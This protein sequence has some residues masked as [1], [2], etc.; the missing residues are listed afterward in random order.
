MGD[1]IGPDVTAMAVGDQQSGL[2]SRLR[3][4]LRLKNLDQ[5]FQT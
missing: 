4:R 1:E 2:I 5:P 3:P